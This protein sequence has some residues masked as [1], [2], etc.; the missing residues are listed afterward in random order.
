VTALWYVV[1]VLGIAVAILYWR[2]YQLEKLVQKE[3]AN[4]T[5][6]AGAIG[7]I[8]AT[9]PGYRHTRIERD[10]LVRRVRELYEDA[11]SMRHHAEQL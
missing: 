7:A 9:C 1:G 8:V 10:D 5:K 2:I 4:S 3:R 6:L 11:D